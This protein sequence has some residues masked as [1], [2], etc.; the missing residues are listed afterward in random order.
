[1]HVLVLYFMELNNENALIRFAVYQ[2][3]LLFSCTG[4]VTLLK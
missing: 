4:S 3:S 2:V 1:V